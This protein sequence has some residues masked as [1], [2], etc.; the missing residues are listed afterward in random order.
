[1][2]YRLLPMRWGVRGGLEVIGDD[3]VRLAS[4]PAP[5]QTSV[6]GTTGG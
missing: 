6:S 2:A 1:M 5:V 3:G 4:A